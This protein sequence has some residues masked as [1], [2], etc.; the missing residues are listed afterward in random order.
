[1]TK[2]YGL[3]V[4]ILA[5]Y[6]EGTEFKSQPGDWL[7]SLGSFFLQSLHENAGIVKQSPSTSSP[8]YYSLVIPSSFDAI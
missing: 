5:L 7:S 8:V 2:P 1:V 6:S 4:S 3:A